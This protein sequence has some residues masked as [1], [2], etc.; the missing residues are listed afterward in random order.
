MMMI[1]AFAAVNASRPQEIPTCRGENLYMGNMVAVD[2]QIIRAMSSL[3]ATTCMVYCHKMRREFTPPD[4]SFS[5]VENMLL[6]MGHVDPK[7]KRPDPKTVNCLER[8]W[9]LTAD[10]EMTNS[11]STFLSVASSLNDLFTSL[12]AS[13]CASF[14]IL[15]GGAI[16]MAYHQLQKVGS[17]EAVPELIK[18]VKAGKL[19]LFG[20]GHRVY[21]TVDPRFT[22]IQAM[23]QE[24]ASGATENSILPVAMEIDRIAREDEYF[25]SRKLK[26]NADFLASFVYT[27]LY[28]PLRLIFLPFPLQRKL[29]QIYQG[30]PHRFH[31]SPLNSC[32]IGGRA[33]PLARSYAWY[34][35]FNHLSLWD[36]ADSTSSQSTKHLA[37]TANIHR[38]H[39]SG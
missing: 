5:F 10:H 9:V 36:F 37:P 31:P 11:T 28:V 34:V 23:V 13:I 14:G 2:R 21:K 4:P 32:T 17:V 20:Y 6:M 33:R 18:R 39:G 35:S 38:C 27:A 8:L 29:M 3:A 25:T 24:L 30:I 12:L 22:E 26:P 16:E 19:R 7:T 1:A 15:H